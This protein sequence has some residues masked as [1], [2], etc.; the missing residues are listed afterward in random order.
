M[1]EQDR[2]Y[3][4]GFNM[5]YE[6]EK[7]IHESI[8]KKDKAVLQS[9]NKILSKIEGKGDRIEGIKKGRSA[10]IKELNLKKER[11]I[12]KDRDNER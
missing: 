2:E 10:F 3:M 8:N 4:A 1:D 9:L 12:Q 5:G 11:Q 7:T 6:I